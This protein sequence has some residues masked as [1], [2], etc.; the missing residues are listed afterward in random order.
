MKTIKYT[1][2]QQKVLGD[3]SENLLVSASAGSGKTATVIQKIFNLITEDNIDIQELLVITF[4]ESASLEMKMRLKDKL[5]K[6]VDGSK[7]LSGQ[8][9][10]L[11]TSDISTIHGFCSK[12]LRKYFFKLDLNPNF[13]VLNE[14]D[15]KFLKATALD[16]VINKYSQQKYE[17][18]VK[19]TS[20]FG[21]GRNFANFKSNIL[22]FY[23]FLCAV[24]NKESFKQTTS[25]LCYEQDL[26]KN[27]ACEDLND[28]LLATVY[29]ITSS[30]ESFLVQAQVSKADYF[31]DFIIK[32]KNSFSLI[33]YKQG[34]LKNRKE[35]LNIELPRVTTKKLD[36]ANADFKGQFKP[37]YD[38]TQKLVRDLKKVVIEKTEEELI[39]DLEN[40]SKIIDKFEEIEN[41][42]EKE[43]VLL[44]QKRNALDFSDLEQKFLELLKEDD[45]KESIATTYKYIFVDEYQDINSVQELILSKLSYCNKMVMVGDIKQSIYG[46]RNSSPNIFV[47]KSI[48][49]EEDSNNGT[50]V[51]LN[52]NFRS[53]PEVLNFV[54]SIFNKCMFASFGGVE[55]EEAGQLKGMT[56]YK[57][58]SDIPIVSLD[59]VCSQTEDDE[60]GEQQESFD[61][62]YSVL[63]D[64]NTYAKKLTTA[65]KEA[66]IVAR[67]ILQIIGKDY[68]DAKE[69]S[70]KKICFGDI[71]ILC[72]GNEFLKEVAKVLMEY[73]IPIATNMVESLYKNKD[74]V[75]LLSLLKIINNFHDDNSLS[76]VLTSLFAG[77]TFDE[78]AY[79]RN[80]YEE[81]FL[82]ESVK[83][84]SV[85]SED[86]SE[87]K[88]RVNNFLSFIKSLQDRL[89]YESLYELLNYLQTEFDF[90]NHFKALPDGA[91]R[92]QY[93]KNFIDSFEDTE[94]N[95]DLNRYLNFVDNYAEEAK[96][97][98]QVNGSVDSVKLGTIHSSKGLEYPI[99]FLVGTGKSFSN[100]TFREEILKD[101]DL[102]L[103]LNSYNLES[104]EK[105]TNL[106]KN[107]IVLNLKKQ[108]KAEELRLLY[109]ALTRAKNHLFVVGHANLN[110]VQYIR[111]A[112][113]AEAVNNFMPWILSSLS[114]LNFNNLIH[115]KKDL[116]D[117][118]KD[119]KVNVGV[120]FDDDFIVKKD[121]VIVF[122]KEAKTSVEA[123]KLF[124][125]FNY[126][127]EEPTNVA[128]KNTVSSMLQEHSE[129]GVN[130][131]DEPKALKIYESSKPEIDATKLG[132]IYHNIM[133][134]I[135]FTS[136]EVEGLKEIDDIIS[137]MK[138]EDKYKNL[139]SPKKIRTCIEKIKNLKPIWAKKE[140][141]FLS[142][143][144]YNFIFKNSNLTDKILIQG[145][146]DLIIKVE[147]KIYL[148]DYKTTKANKPDQLVAKYKIQLDLYAICL[149][150]ALNIK[151]DNTF[152]YSFWFDEFIKIN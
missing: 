3:K 119:F 64:K 42:F 73:K 56:E 152:I 89:V 68:Y 82:Y 91:N 145:V 6:M 104:F 125:L 94:Y 123:Q 5:F 108:E 12:M 107:A 66:M 126:K 118:Q 45:V 76:I 90:L 115:N 8:I 85:D 122:K 92:Y 7:N 103:G 83:A 101:K 23:E 16:K 15:S 127:M 44:K 141:P 47:N 70:S 52:E 57:K 133:Q 61:K 10:K 34:F 62:V 77:F 111:N 146:A 110:K 32:T 54:N 117:N 43:Y 35:L 59:I 139:I 134:R 140:Q 142:Y 39:A 53:N 80:K 120:Y 4:T 38:E 86:N 49:Y 25:K 14:N 136:K 130:F 33:K 98:T 75:M 13:S 63:D 95:Y 69:E 106:A 67:H 18:F 51:N 28:Y 99:V 147:D 19:L 87:L 100:I 93:V 128:L 121:E 20:V 9:E 11:A 79:I 78:L 114:T 60:N 97:S 27:K 102:G 29:Y 22:S 143:L 37:F 21:G 26:N 17:E 148:I 1:P 124:D 48:S 74:V 138:I 2:Q 113:D 150:K 96:F 137:S 149:Q 30:L 129:E 58:V 112:K 46:F 116:C 31:E 72:R 151:I 40:A 109:V 131:N 50:L 24:E 65:R 84:F 41:E 71:A 36:E 135:D 105:N 144:P 81:E 55:Y 132:T 88:A